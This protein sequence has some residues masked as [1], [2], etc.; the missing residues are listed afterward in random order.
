[1]QFNLD[2]YSSYFNFHAYRGEWKKISTVNKH[3]A[4][5]KFSSGFTLNF[6]VVRLDYSSLIASFRERTA[7]INVL[8]V[9]LSRLLLSMDVH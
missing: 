3:A 6:F 1:M 8:K 9:D 2:F 7:F 4:R 5:H